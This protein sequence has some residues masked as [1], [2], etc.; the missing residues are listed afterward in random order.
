LF[1]ESEAQSARHWLFLA[2][3]SAMQPLCIEANRAY[4]AT[5]AY[6]KPPVFPEGDERHT[7]S[8]YGLVHLA[9]NITKRPIFHAITHLLL[10][11]EAA[12]VLQCR[13]VFVV[14]VDQAAEAEVHRHIQALEHIRAAFPS[15]PPASNLRYWHYLQQL[16]EALAGRPPRGFRF[17]VTKAADEQAPDGVDRQ[18]WNAA[19]KGKIDELL[20]L[21]QEWAGHTVIDADKEYVVSQDTNTNTNICLLNYSPNK[22][23]NASCSCLYCE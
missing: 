1:N 15:P 10:P 14:Q 17:A 11:S 5:R 23:T 12:L 9:I 16:T 4:Q 19:Y 20:G 22:Q 8:D 21:C 2:L 13:K 7:T 18:I 3:M 6:S